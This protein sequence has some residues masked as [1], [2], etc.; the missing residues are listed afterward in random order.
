MAGAVFENCIFS[1]HLAVLKFF[2]R[3]ERSI[4]RIGRTHPNG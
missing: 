2:I 1:V 3:Y 4:Y